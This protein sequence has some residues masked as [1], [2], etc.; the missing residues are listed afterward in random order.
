MY[1]QSVVAL[2]M[3]F[4]CIIGV[5]ADEYILKYR[6]SEEQKSYLLTLSGVKKLAA[7]SQIRIEATLRKLSPEQLDTLS[8]AAQ[9]AIGDINTNIRVTDL[10]CSNVGGRLVNLNVDLDAKQTEKFISIVEKENY[11]EFFE[12][13][14]LGY[15]DD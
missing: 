11:V 1:R 12:K 9:K 4:L 14:V 8:R 5:F 3:C 13:N 15:L 7:Q 6:L 2:I 10:G